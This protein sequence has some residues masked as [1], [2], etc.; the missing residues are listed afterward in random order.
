[1]AK[2]RSGKGGGVEVVPGNVPDDATV[3]CPA[4]SHGL[5]GDEAI[6]QRWKS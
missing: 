2:F 6:I 4:V 5:G 3:F 1:M